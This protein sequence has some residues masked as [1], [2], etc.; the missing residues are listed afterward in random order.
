VT[1]VGESVKE[2]TLANSD[3]S[4]TSFNTCT[5]PGCTAM[6]KFFGKY[7]GAATVTV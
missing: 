2:V 3:L 6:V 1:E 5:E 4:F 7:P